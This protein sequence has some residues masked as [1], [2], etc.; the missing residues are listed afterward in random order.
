MNSMFL[1][2]FF[3]Q[4]HEFDIIFMKIYREKT[5]YMTRYRQFMVIYMV[6]DQLAQFV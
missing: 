5:K 1:G 3:D 4:D 2:S 6:M